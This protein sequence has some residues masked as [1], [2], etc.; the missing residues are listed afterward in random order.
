MKI[1]ENSHFFAL[2]SL[3]IGDLQSY[4]SRLTL[5][6]PPESKKF[7]ILVDNRP[8]LVEQDV[9][10][11]HLWQLIVTKSRLSPFANTRAMKA[12]KD[13]RKKLTS[14]DVSEPEPIKLNKLYRWSSLV[15]AALFQQKKALLPVKKLKDS[16]IL[17]KELQHILYG[18]IVFEVAWSDVRGINYLNELQTHTSMALETKSMKRWEFDSVEQASNC[19]SLWFSGTDYERL[20]LGD[21]LDSVSNKEDVF[22]DAQEDI[23]SCCSSGDDASLP[24]ETNFTT[25]PISGPYKRRKIMKTTTEVN[26]GFDESCSKIVN[27]P[28]NSVSS[29]SSDD[30]ENEHTKS[31]FESSS[32][33]DVLILFRFNDPYLPF[34]LRD[35]IMSDLRLLTLLEYGLPSWVIFLQSY[36]LFNQIYRPWMCPLAR[37]L[38]VLISIITV[39]I[40]FY[41]LYK[42]VPLLKA[43]ASHLFGP[44]FDWIETW[45][46]ISRIRY[47]G[48]ML[49]L[50]NFEKTVRWLLMVVHAIKSLFSFVMAPFI[51]PMVE[52]AEFLLPL[53]NICL[54]VMGWIG[55]FVLP[56]WNLCIETV[57]GICSFI[58]IIIESSCGAVMGVLEFVVW[59]LWF[60]LS[61]I[62]NI[63]TQI[64]WVFF[65]ILTAPARLILALVN[66][67]ALLSSNVYYFILE[68]YSSVSG[69]FQ[70]ASASKKTVGAYEPSM[71]KSLWNDLFSQVF[72]AFKSILYGFVAFCSTCNRHRL[73][74][75]NHIQEFLLRFS[76][77][78][79]TSGS[80][81]SS[82]KQLDIIP[83]EETERSSNRLQHQS[84]HKRW[85]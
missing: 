26:E 51:G 34:K 52:I 43:T 68:S 24:D 76:H 4:L 85:R 49:F 48:T 74:I 46:M 63:A 37:G 64:I 73:S 2:T 13:F 70:F 10:S 15:D 58:G 84:L 3:Q 17:S 75:Y 40:G 16:F 67:I 53:W 80:R 1:S 81:H 21:Y 50:H 20:I 42:N 61:V 57:G 47:L 33:K 29:S 31:S 38:Y 25:P 59:P 45:E 14:T 35:I 11:A 41:D 69:L 6:L 83:I 27:S 71:W 65:E 62:W 77:T 7:Y 82:Q 12:K 44:L 32:Y 18:Y 79:N 39:L 72:R 30:F 60:V 28:T 36:P 9:R 55:E 23:D 54:E 19:I 56:F 66:L 5:F 8:W 78:A 22:H